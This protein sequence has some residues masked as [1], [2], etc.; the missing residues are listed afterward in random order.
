MGLVEAA[1]GVAER[2]GVEGGRLGDVLDVDDGVGE[3]RAHGA[4]GGHDT[5][6][7][8]FVTYGLKTTLVLCRAVFGLSWSP[9]APICAC[10]RSRRS[11]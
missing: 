6:L 8:R 10:G 9:R 3:R 11:R 2:G 4:F 7:L 5:R 1:D